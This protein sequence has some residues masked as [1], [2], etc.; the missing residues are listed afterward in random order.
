[1][2]FADL[3]IGFV[4]GGNMAQAILSG[5]IES[6]HSASRLCVGDPDP[7]RL[8][9]VNGLNNDISVAEDNEAA[10]R[11][12]VVVLAVK[13]QVMAEAITSLRTR[14]EGLSGLFVS[15]AAGCTLASLREWVGHGPALV[16]AMPNQPALMGRGMTAMAAEPGLDEAARLRATY[17]MEAIGKALW[18]DDESLV[19]AAT[20]ISGSGPA[21]FYLLMEIM[22]ESARRMGFDEVTARELTR[23]TAAG[24]AA[25]A[26]SE[27][28]DTAELRRR[29]TSPGGTTAAALE[30]MEQGQIRALV[31]EAIQAAQLRAAELGAGSDDD[32]VQGG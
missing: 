27:L 12:E 11:S 30:V 7:D 10:G 24:A 9:A 18:L 19:D 22:E 6:G 15:V 21:Y 28:G 2:N 14:A 25:C 16:R 20:A 31:S 8:R 26:L 13:P 23:Q 1:M 4:G 17:I 29:V 3:S 5:L 32:T